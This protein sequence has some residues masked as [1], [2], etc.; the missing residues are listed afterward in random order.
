MTFKIFVK[1]TFAAL[2]I[3]FFY[4]SPAESAEGIKKIIVSG[5]TNK[6]PVEY[7]TEQFGP[8]G[9]YVELWKLW[10]RKAGVS[11]DYIITS[12]EY[13]EKALLSGEVDVIMGYDLT[14]INS[15]YFTAVP[16]IYLSEIYIYSSRKIP[17]VEKL[18]NLQP[19]RVGITRG[20]AS[21]LDGMNFEILFLVK[22]SIREL[23]KAAENG[24]VNVFI[25]EST[26][27]NYE[28]T[29]S[30]AWKNYIQS[31]KP[32][33]SHSVG[34]AVRADNKKLLVLINSG[35]SSFTEIEKL[36]AERTWSG[37]NF[38]YRVPWGF[39]GT[40]FV[41]AVVIG[42][43]AAVW[44]W[45]Y[46]LQEKIEKATRELKTLKDEAEAANNAKSRFLDN[47]S[48]ELRTPLTL[49]LAPVED[50]MKGRSL[51]KNT[52]EMIQR[53][54]R[55]LLS[56]INDLLELSRIRA[57]M[58]TLEVV[59]SDLCTAVKLYCA[60]MESVMRHRN[61]DLEY[62]L[63]DKP[64]MVF[65]DTK[66]FSR[67]VSNFFS[68]SLKFTDPGGRITISAE[69]NDDSVILKFSDTGSGIP[70][71]MLNSIFDRFSQADTSSSKNYEGTGIGLS[72]VK[73]IAELHGGNVS[74]VSRHISEYPSDHGTEFTVVIPSGIDHF[75]GRDDVTF[76]SSG[77]NEF[78]LPIARIVNTLPERSLESSAK[79]REIGVTEDRP[80][81]LIVED[82][83]DMRSL[84]ENILSE[85]YLVYSAANGKEALKILNMDDEINLIVSD[86]MMP[87]MDG[88][89]LMRNI[90]SDERI[91]DIPLLF[92]TARGDEVVKNEGLE[93]GAVD[94]ITKPFNSDELKLR[95][96]NQMALRVMQNTL[97]RRN[98]ELN[99]KLK[100][101]METRKTP[102]SGDV[103]R[104]LDSL[105][106]FIRVHC[107]DNLSRE[108]LA[109]AS[110]MS[111]DTFSR[112]FNQ[113][114]GVTLSD[115]INEL[116]V[117]E[118]KR[119]L[120]ET[121]DSVT[122]ICFDTGFDSIRTFNRAFKKF[123]G[124][125]PGEFRVGGIDS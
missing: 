93:L 66:K 10:S 116:R 27:A 99:L 35:F 49:I 80:S 24:E 2:I 18:Q 101:H 83:N 110:E 68:N 92:L 115:Y 13:A 5:I 117:K 11:V 86:V 41:I 79:R 23:I 120:G 28:L 54:G 88:H 90:K 105:C 108:D 48:H 1:T 9:I 103:K 67:I 37:G 100:Q 56:L 19:Y 70:A 57:G 31:S 53:N 4:S 97:Q 17:I 47:I 46:Q 106:E 73:E 89:E 113:H 42:G 81:I 72:I 82:N 75:D 63:P 118:A 25:A 6:A 119:R 114:T 65:I 102:V 26:I 7:N 21:R 61:I 69:K 36:V 8:T 38:K 112:M 104:K 64:V 34:A 12:P 124:R 44:W 125:T 94:Y 45:N 55:N 107:T 52:L 96:K 29:K 87:E 77:G 58:V 22:N 39:V 14:A 20:M 74:A 91:K 121:D 3:S 60:E 123:T 122:R 50:A 33:L 84:L 32:V 30:G 95:I 43:V 78:R 109:D 16:D 59:E 40:I 15:K 76:L 98:N 51:E 71:S 111:P 85:N 62:S